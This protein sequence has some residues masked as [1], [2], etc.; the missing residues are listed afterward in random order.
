VGLLAIETVAILTMVAIGAPAA[1]TQLLG[2]CFVGVLTLAAITPWVRASVHVGVFGV[3]A[4]MASLF[5]WGLCA[6]LVGMATVVAV[7]RVRVGDHTRLEV[8][9][10]LVA[11]WLSGAAAV[12][13]LAG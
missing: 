3:T 11:G 12:R 6:A 7:A 8:V 10:G 9:T 13:L 2:A 1:T 4:G 5:S